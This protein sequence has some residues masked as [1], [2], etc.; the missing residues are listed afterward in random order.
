MKHASPQPRH[1][2]TGPEASWGTLSCSEAL[3]KKLLSQ[4]IFLQCYTGKSNNSD[5]R[6]K[7]IGWVTVMP[8]PFRSIQSQCLP[9]QNAFILVIHNDSRWSEKE[10]QYKIRRIPL[11]ASSPG[12]EK[13]L[14]SRQGCWR[15]SHAQHWWEHASTALPSDHDRKTSL[16]QASH[17]LKLSKM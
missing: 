2:L 5:T 4:I 16:L 9:W 6:Q 11:H 17:M 3:T 1:S 10:L 8:R 12:S 15:T 7:A 14:P 13:P